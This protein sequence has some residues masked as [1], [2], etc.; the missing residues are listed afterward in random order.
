MDSPG[1]PS[2]P[3]LE[4]L[5]SEIEGFV[6]EWRRKRGKDYWQRPL[7]GVASAE[8]PLF[9]RLGSVVDPGH[10][11]PCGLLPEARSVVVFFLP[12]D[13][14][15][16]EAN[17][18]EQPLACRA[19]AE[20]YVETNL[21]IRKI[22]GHLGRCLRRAGHAALATPATH[23]FDEEKLVSRWSHKHIGYIAGLGTFGRHHLLI[24]EGGCCGR[25]GSLLTS[26]QIPATPRPVE[27]RCLEKAGRTCLACVSKCRYGALLEDRFDRHACYR[28]CLEND[29]HYSD[30]PLVDVCG[31]CS[32]AVPCSYEIP[33]R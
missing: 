5:R 10:A 28:Q 12:F 8:D 26:A 25:L 7:V 31:K 6:S 24:T 33:G 23:E 4:W 13:R 11:L 16:G 20:S 21:L 30:L 17:D 32:C 22:G 18:R 2:V 14:A 9:G 3:S 29:A 15:L 19:W 27:E 1:M